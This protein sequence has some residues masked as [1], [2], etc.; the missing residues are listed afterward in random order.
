[1]FFKHS[2]CNNNNNNNTTIYS[3]IYSSFVL[4][5]FHVSVFVCLYFSAYIVL[6]VFTIAASWRNK[7]S[8]NMSESVQGR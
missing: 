2:S 1:V 5:D 7:H 8:R 3:L 4:L 6:C